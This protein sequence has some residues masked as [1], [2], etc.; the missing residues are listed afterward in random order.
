V[1]SIGAP[2]HQRARANVNLRSIDIAVCFDTPM[3]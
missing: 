2:A 3:I 1:I